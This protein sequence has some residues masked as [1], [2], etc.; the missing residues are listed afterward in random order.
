MTLPSTES[1]LSN[2]SRPPDYWPRTG[3]RA[4][5][6]PSRADAEVAR[7][8]S[9]AGHQDPRRFA[10]ALGIAI[11]FCQLEAEEGGL[12]AALVPDLDRPFEILCDA[13]TPADDGSVVDLRIAHELGHTLFYDWDS[14]PPVHL[15]RDYHAEEAFCDRFALAMI[16]GC[17]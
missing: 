12:E 1:R 6:A 4:V 15:T 17:E 14:Q 10:A 11:R 3:R 7:L 9:D 8:V 16:R 2:Y 13:W 5:P